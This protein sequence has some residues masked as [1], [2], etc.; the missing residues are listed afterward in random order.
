MEMFSPGGLWAIMIIGGPI[1]LALA[2]L[3]VYV[4]RRRRSRPAAPSS[5]AAVRKNWGKEDVRP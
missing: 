1:A 3:A 5:D 4:Q 2:M